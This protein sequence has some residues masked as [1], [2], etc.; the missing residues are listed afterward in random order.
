MY[1]DLEKLSLKMTLWPKRFFV[2]PNE[3]RFGNH[4]IVGLSFFAIQ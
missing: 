4:G 3:T 1:G 2:Q